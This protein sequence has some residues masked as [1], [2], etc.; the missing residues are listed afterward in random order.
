MVNSEEVIQLCLILRSKEA[1]ISAHLFEF[2]VYFDEQKYEEIP[3]G[4]QFPNSVFCIVLIILRT[5]HE[6]SYFL[7]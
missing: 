1:G 6:R 7:F 3:P 5:T 4:V 2:R